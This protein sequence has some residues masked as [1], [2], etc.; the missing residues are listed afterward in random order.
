[1]TDVGDPAAV[2]AAADK[3]TS[4][5]HGRC[6]GCGDIKVTNSG[7]LKNLAFASALHRIRTLHI[8]AEQGLRVLGRVSHELWDLLSQILKRNQV[9]CLKMTHDPHLYPNL[10]SCSDLVSITSLELHQNLAQS[11]DIGP[12]TGLLS[13]FRGLTNLQLTFDGFPDCVNAIMSTISYALCRPSMSSISR[14]DITLPTTQI[15]SPVID[16]LAEALQRLPLV[17]FH[18][19]CAQ[20]NHCALNVLLLAFKDTS[21]LTSLSLHTN[22]YVSIREE[23]AIGWLMAKNR[24]LT[25]LSLLFIYF[26]SHSFMS[27]LVNSLISNRHSALCILNLH[28]SMTTDELIVLS[29][30]VR[31]NRMLRQVS[32]VETCESLE[33][34][35]PILS[36]VMKARRSP[37]ILQISSNQWLNNG[38]HGDYK[39]KCHGLEE[40][41]RGCPWFAVKVYSGHY[42]YE[43]IEDA[44]R[45]AIGRIDLFDTAW[46]A[47]GLVI[48]FFRAN[49]GNQISPSVIALVP[50]ILSIVGSSVSSVPASVKSKCSALLGSKF[51]ASHCLLVSKKRLRPE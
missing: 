45:N 30:L 25:F 20:L 47:A 41:Q 34:I 33:C 6:L 23:T 26:E 24:T 44:S 29:T 7:Q 14:L 16:Q 37:F 15:A 32:L 22:N 19:S 18:L 35:S 51:V 9:L 39:K 49:F 2:A 46:F 17:V 21:T 28:K 50:S 27:T 48:S 36:T 40:V 8:D 38:L 4:R 1:M 3:D 11:H 13:C 43:S 31:E 42:Q 5:E 10:L 12:V